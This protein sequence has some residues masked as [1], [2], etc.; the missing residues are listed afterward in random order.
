MFVFCF[1]AVYIPFS[2]GLSVWVE[3]TVQQYKRRNTKW[4]SRLHFSASRG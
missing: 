3:K 2:W 4:F 1:S